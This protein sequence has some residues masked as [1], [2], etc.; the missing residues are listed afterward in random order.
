MCVALSLSWHEHLKP[1]G[2]RIFAEATKQFRHR[3]LQGE[4][5]YL[6]MDNGCIGG[7]D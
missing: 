4:N 2:H 6:T 3:W 5:D 1:G 7:P